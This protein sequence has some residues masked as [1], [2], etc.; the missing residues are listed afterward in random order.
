MA[1]YVIRRFLMA[2]PDAVVR[3]A[4]QCAAAADDT[5]ARQSRDIRDAMAA[6]AS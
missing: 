5:D 1:R 6:L 2:L 4:L 3:P